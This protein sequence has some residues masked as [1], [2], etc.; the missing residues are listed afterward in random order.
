MIGI[1]ADLVDIGRFRRS[2][3]R[4]PGLCDRLF[5]PNEQA[6]AERQSDPTERYGG[7]FA[8]KEAVLKALGLGLGG[9]AMYDIEVIRTDSGAPS[10]LLH[11]DAARVSANAGV[12]GWLVTISHTETLAQAVVVAR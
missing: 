3:V 8:S 4:S 11:G 7:R 9:I 12:T 10:L 5:R 6:Y 1:G 2:L